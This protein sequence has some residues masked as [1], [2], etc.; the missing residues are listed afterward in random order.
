MSRILFVKRVPLGIFYKRR[1]SRILP[2]FILYVTVVY[3]FA[4]F[5]GNAL[6]WLDFASTLSFLRSYFPVSPDLFTTGY[7]LAHIWSLNV[8]EHSYVLLSLLTLLPFLKKREGIALIA[9]GC[10]S[11]TILLLYAF[12]PA[13]APKGGTWMKTEAAMSCLVISAGYSLLSERIAPFV[14]PWMPLAA[15]LLSLLLYVRFTSMIWLYQAIITPFLLA[16]SVNHLAQTPSFFRYLLATPPLRLLGISSY[17]IYLWQQPFYIYS[18]KAFADQGA[19][20]FLFFVLALTVGV[21]IFYWFENPSR[22][23]LNKVW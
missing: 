10:L 1:I 21:V 20:N 12:V 7:P 5:Q 4:Y 17:S 23:Y 6:G 11:I 18:V 14:K 16:F 22:T 8:E 9:L 13:I 15:L 19:L 3:G 2:S